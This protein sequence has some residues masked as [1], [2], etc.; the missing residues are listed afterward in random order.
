MELAAPKI[1]MPN[2][3]I[4]VCLKKTPKKN[5]PNLDEV[6]R[7]GLDC[8]ADGIQREKVIDMVGEALDAFKAQKSIL[9]KAKEQAPGLYDACIML[10]RAMIELCGH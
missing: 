2:R 9:D 4:W 6:L 8:H 3:A 10:L 1:M 5:E 7:D